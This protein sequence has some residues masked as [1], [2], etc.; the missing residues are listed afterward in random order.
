MPTPT[1]HDKIVS[2]RHR[3]R[4][5][6]LWPG[7]GGIWARVAEMADFGAFSACRGH[8]GTCM[9]GMI[10]VVLS[11]C[12]MEANWVVDWQLFGASTFR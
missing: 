3:G 6:V 8:G 7:S 9:H 5:G 12:P 1:G 11:R 4:G 2:A 10:L